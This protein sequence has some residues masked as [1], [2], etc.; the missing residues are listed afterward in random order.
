MRTSFPS[1]RDRRNGYL[2]AMKE[3]DLSSVYT[4]DFNINKGHGYQETIS[5]LNEY[6]HITALFC[7]NDDVGGAAIK[8]V[9]ALGKRVPADVSIIGYDDTYIAANTHPALTT[10]HVD[11][12]AM[13]RAAVHLLSLRLENPE[14]GAH[15]FDDPHNPGGAPIRQCFEGSI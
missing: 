5:L 7:I 9:Q 13:G 2:R 6:P 12:I 1:L 11:T 8:A 3:N 10:M 14:V 4:C 15:D